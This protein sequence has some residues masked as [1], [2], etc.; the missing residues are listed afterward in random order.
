MAVGKSEAQRGRRPWRKPMLLTQQL[1][2]P[3][4]LLFCSQFCCDI[5]SALTCVSN[6]AECSGNGGTPASGC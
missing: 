3:N 1:V 2:V 4:N 5:D 6:A